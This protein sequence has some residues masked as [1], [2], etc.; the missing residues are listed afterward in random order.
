MQAIKN[1]F[2]SNV[3]TK[4]T[5]KYFLKHQYG[6]FAASGTEVIEQTYERFQKL[7]SQL[8]MHEI[9]TLSLDDLFNNIKTYEL[10][11][12]NTANTQGAADRSK[13]TENLSDAVIYSFFASQPRY[14][15][16][17]PPCTGNFLP[18]K[19]DLVYHSLDDYVDEYVSESVVEKPTIYSNEPK[20]IRKENRAPIIEEIDLILQIMR[21]LMDDLL[22]LEAIPIE[23]KLLGKD[24]MYSVD[25]K[26]VVPQGGLT[27][28][29][30]K[31]T[32]DE[33][34]LW[35]RRLG[36]VNFKTI[37][38]L[39]KGNLVRATI[40]DITNEPGSIASNR[41]EKMLLLTWHESSEP[42]KEPVCDSV[43]PSSL[44]QHD[45]ST[46]CK[47]FVCDSITPRCM[48]DCML[49]PP[50]D[51]SAIT[52]TQV[53]NQFCEMKSI[54]RE[55]SVAR[56][57]Q[58]NGVAERKNR[59]LIEAA[60][61]MLADSKFPTTLWAEAVNTAYYVHNRVLV[62]KPHNK[63]PY[64]LFLG[65]KHALSF[66]RPFGCPFTILNTIDHLGKFDGKADER[67]FVGYSTNSKASRVFNSRT[68]IVEENMHVKFS[69]N[70]PNIA[71][72]RPNWLF[73]IDALTK[74]MNYK[75]VVAGNQSNGSAG[76]ARVET[77]PD[78]DFI[79]L[80][81]W[82]QDPLFYSSSK[83]SPGDGFKPSREEEKKDTEDLGNE[84]SEASIIE[85]P[86]VNQENDSVNSTNII[87]VVSLT[88]NAASNEV[89]AIGRK[90]SIELPDDPNMPKLED[91]SIFED[92]NEDVFGA[93]D[94]LNN[95]ESTFQ[96]SHILITRIQKE[97]IYE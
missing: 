1:R 87:N 85:E 75:H 86:R 47:V 20:T 25:S 14:N 11:D 76:K 59:T 22:P 78:K 67:F 49:T 48:P 24:N 35:H 46:P 7:I 54:K 66:M 97:N 94:N 57:P 72:S 32:S 55:F 77:V 18:P 90:S 53:M 9:E 89:N 96:V 27:C 26:N 15:V 13:T 63:T 52:Y 10:E 79:M 71:G 44:P 93:D 74:S 95:L 28:L 31:A 42:T 16:F 62:I 40:E 92:S 19:L 56:T 17:P 65:R 58:Q 41:T 23:G 43:T 84:D 2:G 45:S 36:H 8:D 73:D 39:V 12:V 3:T 81:L 50:T 29:F 37:N 5:Q 83:D 60:R 82:T 91:I 34:T 64:E 4:K 30:A 69:E 38:K 61:M 6:N 33:S 88:V 21:K 70:T 80:S 51:E 68:R